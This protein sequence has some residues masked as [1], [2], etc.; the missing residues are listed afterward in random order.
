MK[1]SSMK[2]SFYDSKYSAETLKPVLLAC[3]PP[4]SLPKKAVQQ[5]HGKV[6]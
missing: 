2:G 1:G 4:L 3:Y 6:S 5:Q